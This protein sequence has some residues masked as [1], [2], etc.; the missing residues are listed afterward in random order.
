METQHPFAINDILKKKPVQTSSELLIN[1]TTSRD[2]NSANPPRQWY[3][4]LERLNKARRN[5]SNNSDH[6]DIQDDSDSIHNSESDDSG[7]EHRLV[8]DTDVIVE[9]LEPPVKLEIKKPVNVII[10]RPTCKPQEKRRVTHS[11]KEKKCRT[12]FTRSQINRLEKT[13]ENKR[14]VSTSERSALAESL[15]LSETQVR[16]LY[17]AYYFLF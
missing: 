3:V 5:G 8:V 2:L 13:F 9:K 11:K 10:P 1:S 15:N 14:Y 6:S 16:F 12:I 7:S 4:S 17:I